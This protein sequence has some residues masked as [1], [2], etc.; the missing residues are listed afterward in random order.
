[1]TLP[2]EKALI[3]MASAPLYY[4]RSIRAALEILHV[5]YFTGITNQKIANKVYWG[6]STTRSPFF[7]EVDWGD[8]S[9]SPHGRQGVTQ[10]GVAFELVQQNI[11]HNHRIM[12]IDWFAANDTTGKKFSLA[13]PRAESE[14]FI[15]GK[16]IPISKNVRAIHVR[17]GLLSAIEI[18]EIRA[19]AKP[20]RFRVFVKQ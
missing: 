3:E 5:G 20:Y 7:H 6:I 17:S 18:E 10:Y 15:V 4:N 11:K 1:M 14:E 12:P 2:E 19:A 16:S 9:L 13:R 8:G